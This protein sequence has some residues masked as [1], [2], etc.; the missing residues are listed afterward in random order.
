[1]TQP[2]TCE[3]CGK[4]C[5]KEIGHINRAKKIGL[6]L[7]CDRKCFGLSKRITKAEKVQAKRLYDI[8][9]RK[10][11]PEEKKKKAAA[12]FQRTYDPSKAAVVRKKRMPYHLEYCRTDK[13]RKWKKKYDKK[14]RAR[15][16]YGDFWESH[17][18]LREIEPHIDKYEAAINNQILNKSQKRKRH[19]KIKRRKSQERT[20]GNISISQRR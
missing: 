16:D 8:E 13:Y 10:R 4:E 18:L 2:F 14:Y 12:Y 20:L 7:Y 15:K 19:E 11:N 9:Y 6:R 3:Y 1:M 17:L 5:Y